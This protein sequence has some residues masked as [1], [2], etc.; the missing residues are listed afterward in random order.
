MRLVKIVTAL[1]VVCGTGSLLVAQAAA[2]PRRAPVRKD[3]RTARKEVRADHKAVVA[4]KRQLAKDAASGDHTAVTADK[5]KLAA[6]RKELR[7]D[8]QSGRGKAVDARQNNQEKRIQQG[9]SKG[10]LTTE[11]AAKLESQQKS[12]ADM[13]GTFKSDGKLTHDEMK[14]LRTA[15]NGASRDIWAEKHDTDGVQMPVV[16]LGKDI[17]AKSSLTDAINGD[18]MTT[19]Q[20]RQFTRDFRQMLHLKHELATGTL[21]D[22]QRTAMQTQYD[23]LLNTYFE[24]RPPTSQPAA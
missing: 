20:A 11:E 7:Q 19:E 16:R 21:T 22:E 18:T 1:L 13:E 15:L 10:Y 8:V 12:I 5:A 23:T 17:Y 24:V 2:G 14:Q 4:D 9:I 3:I 6:D